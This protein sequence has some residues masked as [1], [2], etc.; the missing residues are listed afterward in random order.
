MRQHGLYNLPVLSPTFENLDFEVI[1]SEGARG[2][3]QLKDTH[4]APGTK[5]TR[6][7]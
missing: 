7:L 1:R 5:Q 6:E 2:R 4:E 3:K